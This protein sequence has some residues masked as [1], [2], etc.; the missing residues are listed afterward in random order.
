MTHKIQDQFENLLETEVDRREFL[1]YAG[2]TLLGVFGVSS[3]IKT[4]TQSTP[5]KK[6]AA[7]NGYGSATYGGKS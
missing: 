1:T 4:L 6:H 2:A 3:L 5:H 7:S